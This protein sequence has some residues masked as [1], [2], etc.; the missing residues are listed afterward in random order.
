MI[1]R[2]LI[3]ALAAASIV[4]TTGANAVYTESGM[5]A[6]QNG[7]P[8]NMAVWVGQPGNYSWN[9]VNARL[10]YHPDRPDPN[11][12]DD[13]NPDPG[14]IYIFPDAA[15]A[16]AWW[17]GIT[18]E[19]PPAGIPDD[20]VAY[21]HWVLDNKSGQFPGIMA[22]SDDDGIYSNNCIMS[23]GFNIPTADGLDIEPK[24][25]GNY[26]G[27]SKRF[28]M[29]VLKADEPIDLVF[30]MTDTTFINRDPMKFP[31]QPTDLL[32]EHWDQADV[33]DDIFRIY[34][35]MMKWGNGTGTDSDNQVRQGTRLAGFK[36][37]LGFID[38]T[39]ANPVFTP[40]DVNG[41]DGITYDL[42]LCIPDRYFDVDPTSPTGADG[43]C[44]E[45]TVEIYQEDEF[46][47]FSPSMYST[48]DDNRT[49]PIGGYW[50]KKPAGIY[51]PQNPKA[52]LMEVGAGE[53]TANYL[54]V[55]A[56][57][58]AGAQ[59]PDNMFGYL[60]YY[61]V[62]AGNDPGNIAMGIYKDDDGDP[63]TEGSLYAWW[64]GSAVDCCFRWG[65]D[66]DMDGTVG[67]NA[68]GILTQA[69][70]DE[71]AS[72]PL[73]ENQVLDAPRYEFGYM[74]D[75]G[76]LNSDTHIKITPAYN[77]AANP[78]FTVR[79]TAQSTADAKVTDPGVSD[80]AW[81]ANPMPA[82]AD[83]FDELPDATTPPSSDGG[84]D[85]GGLCSYDPEGRF[86]PI[87]PG[88]IL[89]AL[90]YLGWRLKRRKAK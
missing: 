13:A 9:P 41:G 26:R 86:D 28:K 7:F 45:A 78:R 79:F 77:V 60:M 23:S 66:P 69:E 25:C 64:D 75:L 24:T 2:P 31:S 38:H 56:N 14:V 52:N 6:I 20:A 12:L 74:D 4:F 15:S 85:S 81:V 42:T 29:V 16:N 68:W 70:L 19:T 89:A 54:D 43:A 22:I 10:G 55:G 59:I 49:G 65:I 30:N 35:Y 18:P 61:G 76:G 82:A 40:A 3:T 37:E 58:A 67:P 71:I 39:L 51:P 5:P 80:A 53:T 57:Q 83:F 72:R 63:S 48:I 73:A 90:A 32:Y 88:L 21:I 46:A 62:F 34:R 50:D 17:N 11:S 47:T 87:L 84:G 36:V 33:Q 8:I 44:P 1:K 27:S